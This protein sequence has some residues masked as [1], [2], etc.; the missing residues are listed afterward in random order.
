MYV[1]TIFTK[2]AVTKMKFTNEKTIKTDISF[3]TV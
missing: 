2:F 1:Y 3:F